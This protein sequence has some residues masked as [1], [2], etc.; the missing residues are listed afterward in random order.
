MTGCWLVKKNGVPVIE[1]AECNNY[2]SHVETIS[3]ELLIFETMLT[4][5]HGDTIEIFCELPE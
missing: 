1:P 2:D 3:L 4:C 5:N